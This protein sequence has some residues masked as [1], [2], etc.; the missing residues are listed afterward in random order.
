[1]PL[2]IFFQC[3]LGKVEC[4]LLRNVCLLNCHWVWLRWYILLISCVPWDRCPICGLLQARCPNSY[5]DYINQF[6]EGRGLR[7]CIICIGIAHRLSIRKVSRAITKAGTPHGKSR[8][9]VARS[10]GWKFG[11]NI[12][13][14]RLGSM[15]AWPMSDE[16]EV[17][18][19]FVFA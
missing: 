19:V 14:I 16:A 15:G 7:E 5:T 2:R 4:I 1:M 6:Y 10:R 3:S 8:V 13:W 11:S 12:L 18:R 17:P 9:L